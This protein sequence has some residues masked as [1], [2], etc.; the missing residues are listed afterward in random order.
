VKHVFAWIN[1]CNTVAGQAWLLVSPPKTSIHEGLATAM[2]HSVESVM[3]KG[4]KTKGAACAADNSK[5]N[6]ND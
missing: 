5:H 3:E 4:G 6:K 1:A 2:K